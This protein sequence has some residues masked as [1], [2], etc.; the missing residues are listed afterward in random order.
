MK[1]SQSGTEQQEQCVLWPS[2][3]LAQVR[4]GSKAVSWLPWKER[5]AA[6]PNSRKDRQEWNR[7]QLDAERTM[8]Q[9]C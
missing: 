5:E 8:L 3:E 9:T 4:W 7:S 6:N 2:Q 1:S